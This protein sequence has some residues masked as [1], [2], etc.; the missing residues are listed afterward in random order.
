MTYGGLNIARFDIEHE[1]TNVEFR[2]LPT[3]LVI[4]VEY[5]P[6]DGA[7]CNG[8][9]EKKLALIAEGAKVACW[10]SRGTSRTWSSPTRHSSGP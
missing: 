2:K 6:V 3:E 1:F 7:K 8:R 5:T 9:V 10:S 4:A